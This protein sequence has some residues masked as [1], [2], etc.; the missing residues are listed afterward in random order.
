MAIRGTPAGIGPS[1][2]CSE[3]AKA[4]VAPRIE[5]VSDLMAK[6]RKGLDKGKDV[7]KEVHQLRVACRRATAAVEAFRP[8]LAIKPA[9]SIRKDLKAI[10]KAAGIRRDRDVLIEAMGTWAKDGPRK[11]VGAHRA[12]AKA[13]RA[14]SNSTSAVVEAVSKEA[15]RALKK[16]AGRLDSELAGSATAES[17]SSQSYG[18]LARAQVR[19]A[20]DGALACAS[21]GMETN[22]QVHDLRVA[23][24]RL[25]YMVETFAPCFEA[26]G[27]KRILA[28]ISHVQEVMGVFN[29]QATVCAY[30]IE[31]R[32][33][34]AAAERESEAK[35]AALIA[36]HA[37]R[38]DELR[39]EAVVAWETLLSAKP[40][41]WL[42][43][44]SDDGTAD[45]AGLSSIPPTLTKV[46][47]PKPSRVVVADNVAIVK[48]SSTIPKRNGRPVR[49]AAIDVG[50]NSLRLI[51][52]EAD[53]AGSYR[54]LDDEKETTR[55][56][57][58][59]HDQ[60]RMNEEAIEHSIAAIERMVS[61]SKGYGAEEI[62]V[63]G[64]AAAREAANADDLVRGV[65]ERTGLSMRIIS[66]EEEAQYAYRSASRAFDM[67]SIPTIVVDIGGG[68]TEVVLSVGR[69]APGG[70]QGG[71][72][73][74]G[75]GVVEQIYT[76]PM[77]AVRMTEQFG[78]DES[79]TGERFEEMVRFARKLIK[80]HVGKPP[81]VPQLFV[82]TGGTIT[83]LGAIVANRE[84]DGSQ[85]GYVG[86]SVQEMEVKRSDVKHLIDYLR[87]LPLRHR[88][89]V[90][91]LSAERA[92]I[93][94][95]G[96]VLVD[97][98]LKRFD[99]NAL[100][101]HEG[102]IRDGLLLSMVAERFGSKADVSKHAGPDAAIK[103]VRRFAKACSYERAHS[104]HVASLSV[105][106][107]DQLVAAGVLV[108]SDMET[109]G[110]R[111]RMLLE[112][113]AVL[114]DIGY[115]VNYAQHH[116]HSYHLI[117]HAELPGLT[118]REV[119]IVAC[120][121]RYHRAAG[122]KAKHP[123]YGAMDSVD[124]RLVEV[125][126]GVLRIADGL[127]RTHTQAVHGTSVHAEADDLVF[128]ISSAI[129]PSVDIWGAQRKADVFERATGKRVRFEWTRAGVESGVDATRP[130]ASAKKRRAVS[131]KA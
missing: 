51:V 56:G 88:S 41:A 94:V 89:R 122:P 58:G 16:H 72:E 13:L 4:V 75:E 7:A 121:A 37:D 59:L 30:I 18:A 24:K 67:R 96:F 101:V 31:S 103:G 119:Q 116:K 83:A 123:A 28:E 66:A 17:A 57:R 42:R 118:T 33:L 49:L 29:D 120:I 108:S 38:T 21:A 85:N 107:F 91:G 117:V 5:S 46:I 100:R 19:G 6:V 25:R 109:W 112:A 55:L 114:H 2:P 9:K 23:I 106:L 40:W 47:E 26:K 44:W 131:A 113:G 1:T 78:G 45:L 79:A 128:S 95:A 63:V 60:G 93:V 92:D 36:L 105:G 43:T 48:P 34:A 68:S 35:S 102:G 84:L 14:D 76:I 65:R 27:W 127:D 110:K 3:A 99:C 10:R 111:E 32:K 97:A 15:Q 22:E 52:A 62:W 54:V 129:E 126:S 12:L 11:F 87:K 125:L 20:V 130:S 53:G 74:L 86:R 104:E 70:K 50:S 90:A 64:T 81:V 39:Q 8:C 71:G 69:A 98:L 61:I 77:G 124:R 80:Q 73:V 82:G 115:L